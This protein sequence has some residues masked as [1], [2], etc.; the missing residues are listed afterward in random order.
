MVW[1]ESVGI[2]S[3]KKKLELNFLGAINTLYIILL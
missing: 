1:G 2:S 3:G